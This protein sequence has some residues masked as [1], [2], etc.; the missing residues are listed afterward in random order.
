MT[1][2]S[3]LLPLLSLFPLLASLPAAGA[4]PAKGKP[5]KTSKDKK[6]PIDD[7]QP[8]GMGVQVFEEDK[9]KKKPPGEK[10]SGK[11]P[12]FDRTKLQTKKEKMSEEKLDAA[13][14]SLQDVLEID[15]VTDPKYPDTLVKLADMYWQKSDLYFDQSQS[16][17]ILKAIY[18]AEESKNPAEIQR[19][20]GQQAALLATCNSWR[21]K[22][23]DTYKRIEKDHANYKDIDQVLYSTGFHLSMMGKRDEGYAYYTKLL[24][25]RPASSLVPDTLLNVGDYFFGKND[26]ETSLAFYA[27][28][29]QYGDSHVLGYSHYKQGWCQFNLGDKPLSV[30]KFLDTIRWTDSPKGKMFAARIDLKAEA[31]VDLVRAYS[32]FGA[33]DKALGFLKGIAPDI[34]VKLVEILGQIYNEDSNYTSAVRLF[35]TLIAEVGDDVRALGYQ[36]Q[37]VYAVF[38]MAD[39]ERVQKEIGELSAMLEKYLGRMNAATKKDEIAELESLLR[40]IGT[41]Y[42]RE[43][44]KTMDKKTQAKALFIYEQYL[45]WFPDAKNHYTMAFNVA[46]LAFQMGEYERAARLFEQVLEIK[47]DGPFSAQALHSAILCYMRLISDEAATEKDAAKDASVYK[48]EKLPPL[49]QKLITAGEK[50]VKVS[51]PGQED[52][53]TVKYVLGK[54]YYIHNYFEQSITPL[55]DLY[56]NHKGFS[57]MQ[58]ASRLILSAHNL[59]RDIRGLNKW[60][61]TFSKDASLMSGEF[62]VIVKEILALRDFNECRLMEGD[63]QFAAAANC[64]MAYFQKFP[65]C[66]KQG[67]IALANAAVMYRDAK[68]IEKALL[69]SEKLYNDCSKADN[70]P[71]A[72]FNIG[73]IYKT[74]AVYSEAAYFYE[75]YAKN[76]PKHDAELLKKALARAATYRRALGDYDLAIKDYLEF[77]KRFPQDKRA[78]F[79]FFEI[80][81]IYET[82]AKW[83]GVVDHF[84][85]YLKSYGKNAELGQVL[86]AHTKMGIAYWKQ[87]KKKEALK[88]FATS[89]EGYV[90][91][92]AKLKTESKPL[93]ITEDAAEAVATAKFYEGD[94]ILENMK[95]VKLQL[96]QKVFQERLGQ[97]ITLLQEAMKKMLEVQNFKRP[98]WEIAALNHIGQAYQDLS[99][100]LETA[101]IPKN[102]PEEVRVEIQE[103]FLKKANEMREQAIKAYRICLE[104]ARENKWFNEHSDNAEKN[105]AAL[106]LS[107][108]FTREVRPTPAFYRPN[109]NVPMPKAGRASKTLEEAVK[110]VAGAKPD[111]QKAEQLLQQAAKEPED[112]GLAL[113]DLGLLSERERKFSEAAK[114]YEDAIAKDPKIADAHARLGIVKQALGQGSEKPYLEASLRLDV[115]NST[116]NTR[117]ATEAIAAKEYPKGIGLIRKALVGD[118][119]SMDAYQN[120]ARIY[121]E[122]GQLQMAK[123]VCGQ[124]LEMDRDNASMHNLAGLVWLKLNDV[125]KAIKQFDG[126]VKGDSRFVEG[127]LNLAST[128]LN[129]ADFDLAAKHYDAA[130]KLEP[131]NLDATLGKAV[132]MRGLK[133]YDEAQKGYESILTVQPGDVDVRY[134]LCLLHG[135]YQEKY[136]AAL[137]RCEEFDQ[138]A[139]PKHPKAKEVKQRIKGIKQTIEVLKDMPAKPA[140][141]PAPDAPK[142]EKA[143]ESK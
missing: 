90:A 136:E 44:E 25:E 82:Q 103:E 21:Q 119:D 16:T 59:R 91:H 122:T 75:L 8:K 76:H 139:N 22:A 121:Y 13:I 2:P 47:P 113:Y 37:I 54:L 32:F 99:Q 30:K 105:L 83:K 45:K 53:D 89:I 56:E 9:S 128:V 106:D 140:T 73:T 12:G 55:V 50:F 69:A 88:E 108:K 98:N 11:G 68:M 41:D 134:N 85:K 38:K 116:A 67:T 64:Y 79:V 26:F 102:V 86:T 14:Q 143:P 133:K 31:Q 100:S 129:Y 58:E 52:L 81:L 123:L 10:L 135:E 142:E 15:D 97:K 114:F 4:P 101:P 137:K 62:A 43:A 19:V 29:E 39:K 124:A 33:P 84:A 6:P 24:K 95:G 77:Y 1:R 51:K 17:E 7:K 130:E 132:A 28:V 70:A 49:E 115:S 61:E 36:R 111:W 48:P 40:I 20:K 3:W 63:K 118:A 46:V 141:P 74:I 23:V 112:P 5:P 65:G 117:A 94:V 107:Y 92:E 42:H 72:L 27:K 120:L 35:K 80:G 71:M 127:H 110:A 126:A 78:P 96:P 57:Q 87:G 93:A 34:Y 18:D 66:T 109:S 104:K 138:M 131:K 60:A 125:R